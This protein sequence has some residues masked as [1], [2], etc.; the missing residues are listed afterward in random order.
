MGNGHQDALKGKFQNSLV[1][2]GR[3]LMMHYDVVVGAYP[4]AHLFINY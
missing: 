4:E 1:K 2:V 3:G